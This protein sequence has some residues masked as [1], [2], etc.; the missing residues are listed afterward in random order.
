MN[1]RTLRP[2]ALAALLAV[3]S[4]A[5]APSSSPT[6][7]ATVGGSVI[8]REQLATAT[9]VFQS[10]AGVQQ[11]GCGSVDGPNDTQE[12]A[13][14]RFSLGWLIRYRLAEAYAADPSHPVTVPGAVVTRSVQSFMSSFG[15][16]QVDQ[17]LATNGATTADLT[18]LVGLDMLQRAVARA[19]ALASVGGAGLRSQYEQNI[20]QYTI[21]QLD[22]IVV[23]SRT[24]AEQLY[25]QVTA[26]GATRD[27]FLALAK[28]Y[29]I[30]PSAKQNSGSLGSAYISAL[31]DPALMH[32]ALTLQNGQISKPVRTQGGWEVVRMQDKQVTPFS[33]VRKQLLQREGDTSF[34]TFLKRQVASGAIEVSP[35]YGR[36]DPQM[37]DVVRIGSTD[38]SATPSAQAPVNATPTPTP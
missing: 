6:T 11:Q 14:A 28:K 20:G 17:T 21:V 35:A 7:A 30:D 3:G 16:K 34:E 19:M 24:R 22:H 37:L 23:K 25:R 9:R 33:Q 5:C 1:L 13:C 12:A 15:T 18:H 27:D 31:S 29:S 4:S 36:F 38:P 32:V 8:T 10:I 2:V 26:P